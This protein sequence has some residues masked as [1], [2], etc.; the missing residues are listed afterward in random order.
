MNKKQII[1]NERDLRLFR[2]IDKYRVASTKSVFLACGFSSIRYTEI[3]IKK[4]EEYGYLKRYC[5]YLAFPHMLAL[6][7]KALKEIGVVAKPYKPSPTTGLHY[8]GVGEIAAFLAF[9]HGLDATTDFFVDKDF[10][11]N[12]ELKDKYQLD[13]AHRPDIIFTAGEITY[14]VEYERTRKTNKKTMENI[15]MNQLAGVHQRWVIDQIPFDSIKK[16]CAREPHFQDTVSFLEYSEIAH[17]LRR[18]GG[19]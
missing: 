10:R 14:F 7:G 13:S 11:H 2:F 4:L 17:E 5:Y 19:I 8:I 3:R 16:E 12:K 9:K 1:L 18:L 15:L 6:T